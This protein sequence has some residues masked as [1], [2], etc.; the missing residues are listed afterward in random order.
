M[1]GI[2]LSK[3][4]KTKTMQT[5]LVGSLLLLGLGLAMLMQ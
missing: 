1:L 3:R 2:W 5:L 4:G